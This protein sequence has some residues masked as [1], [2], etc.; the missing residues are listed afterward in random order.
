[1]FATGTRSVRAFE[2]FRRGEAYYREAHNNP[3]ASLLEANRHFERALAL[4]S[5][6]AQAAV[7]HSDLYAHL[8]MDGPGVALVA[9][10]DLTQTAAI[11]RLRADL[12]LAA[13]R[14]QDPTMRAVVEINRRVK[15]KGLLAAGVRG[16]PAR[17]P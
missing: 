14:T 8:V 10:V 9:G 16:C 11:E 2:E 15:R 7:Y 12:D 17:R 4:D 3:G 5:S 6:Y 13:A 1:M